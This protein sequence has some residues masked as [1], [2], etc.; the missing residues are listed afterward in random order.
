MG[1]LIYFLIL[2]IS[3]PLLAYGQAKPNVDKKTIEQVYANTAAI[4]VAENEHNVVVDTI[5]KKQEKLASLLATL[6][7]YKILFNQT[8]ENFKGFGPESGI[9]KAIFYKLGSVAK[10]S[11]TAT[12]AMMK[13]NFTGKALAAFRIQELVFEAT[14]LGNLFCNVV[15]NGTIKNPL[16]NDHT[17]SEKD[18]LNLLNRSERLNL[19][20]SISQELSKIDH[21]LLMVEYYCKHNSWGQ[22]LSQMDRKTYATLLYA[23]HS[24]NQLIDRWNKL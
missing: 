22:L 6:A 4:E 24:T 13:T 20:V 16:K 23:K 2:L 21:S 10:R 12:D 15:C 8:L 7:S 11:V 18:K 9:Y 14:H 19:A 17:S 3:T 1:K 5:K